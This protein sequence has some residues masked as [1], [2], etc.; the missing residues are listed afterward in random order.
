MKNEKVKKKGEKGVS[1]QCSLNLD[2]DNM[3]EHNIR[4]Q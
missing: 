4:K 3:V 2:R 1:V